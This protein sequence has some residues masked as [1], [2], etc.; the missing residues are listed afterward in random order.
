MKKLLLV[1]VSM[2]FALPA[3]AT[4]VQYGWED[5]GDVLGL[6]GTGTPPIIA[7]NVGAPDPVHEGERSLKLEDNS[8]TGTPEAYVIWVKGLVDGDV[9]EAGFW[10]Y[11]TTPA[12]SPSCRIWAH[13]NDDPNDIYGY[14]GSAGGNDDYGPGEGWD[15]TTHSWTVEAGHTG[16]VI[17]ARTYSVEGD[18]VWIDEMFCIAPDSAEIIIPE[19]QTPVEDT[20][21]SAIKALYR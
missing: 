19:G 12:A 11:D 5:L 18:T 20:S 1:A 14:N 7:T 21:W 6:Y 10:R 8:P 15:Q 13:W 3:F 9:V 16:I 17:V 2:L 4:T